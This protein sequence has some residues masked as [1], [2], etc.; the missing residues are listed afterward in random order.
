[1]QKAEA[2]FI[3]GIQQGMIPGFGMPLNKIKTLTSCLLILVNDADG[4]EIA[5]GQG[6]EDVDHGKDRGN[7]V[8]V[9]TE[10]IRKDVP[11]PAN[12]CYDDCG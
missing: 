1:M 12:L 11:D 10:A 9:H 4:R 7:E 2:W 3:T 8:S 6:P 5:N